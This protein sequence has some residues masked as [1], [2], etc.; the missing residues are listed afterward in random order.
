M[1]TP[2]P[3]TPHTPTTPTLS[4]KDRRRY[5]RHR[6]ESPCKLIELKTGRALPGITRDVSLGGLLVS[7][8]TAIPF[9]AGE[10]I[11][12][13]VAWKGQAVLDANTLTDAEV[14][15]ASPLFDGQQTLAIR[16]INA[17]ALAQAA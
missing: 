10:R 2:T 4:G 1:Q 12:I 9:Q 13:G 5:I 8:R 6:V 16:R 15:R 14:V 7:L 3:H 17:A 11:K